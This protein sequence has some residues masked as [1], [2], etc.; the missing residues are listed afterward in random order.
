[1][2]LLVPANL[3]DKAKKIA[4]KFANTKPGSIVLVNKDELNIINKYN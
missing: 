1:M 3:T 2:K 4:S